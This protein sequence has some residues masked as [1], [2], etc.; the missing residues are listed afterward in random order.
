[1][2]TRTGI[3]L[4]KAKEQRATIARVSLCEA[5]FGHVVVLVLSRDG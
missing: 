4:E 5:V 2:F 1:M 3:G